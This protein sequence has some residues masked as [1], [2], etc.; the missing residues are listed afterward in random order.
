MK[1][2]ESICLYDVRTRKTHTV[3]NVGMDRTTTKCFTLQKKLHEA[4]THA[5]FV[6]EHSIAT[7]NKSFSDNYFVKPCMMHVAKAVC[8][9][10]TTEL[11]F[12]F[13]QNKNCKLHR[14]N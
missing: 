11:S 3:F 4:T 12:K 2:I 6:V 1:N 13:I 14:R 8:P 9:E 10:I 7:H 5:R